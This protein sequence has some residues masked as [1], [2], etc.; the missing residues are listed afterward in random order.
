IQRIYLDPRR[1]YGYR[2]LTAELH[3]R[4]MLV[5][6][7]RVGRRMQEDNRIA[8]GQRK[9]GGPTTD[10][11]HD[12]GG[13]LNW[14]A[15]MKVTAVN[16]LWGAGLTYIRWLREFVFWAVIL[17]AYSRRVV[18]RG[19]AR[20]L[21]R[22]LAQTALK[23]AMELRR[24]QPGLVHH[25]DRGIPY[26]GREYTALL[27]THGLIPSMAGRGIPTTRTTFHTAPPANRGERSL[28]SVAVP[29]VWFPGLCT[30]DPALDPHIGTGSCR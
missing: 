20:S 23:A 28:A 9:Y 3:H 18:G 25:S 14:A 27:E 11:G 22:E 10:S 21:H 5:N 24:P 12:F 26:A 29:R 15:R 1:H 16:Q 2:R 4:G 7:K 13:Y 6:R 8:I 17:D 30:A 19:L